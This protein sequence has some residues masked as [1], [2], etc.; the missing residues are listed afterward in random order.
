MMHRPWL[1]KSRSSRHLLL[2]DVFPT[3]PLTL[4]F[5]KIWE[6]YLFTSFTY[7]PHFLVAAKNRTKAE[8]IYGTLIARDDSARKLPSE[9]FGRKT[10]EQIAT[11][12]GIS[13][14]SLQLALEMKGVQAQPE[15]TMRVVA[16]KN[17][18][19][20]DTL[21]GMLESMIDTR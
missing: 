19:G 4:S 21:R 13:V 8:T 7:V 20:I 16:D 10:L 12:S 11:E 2:L 18:I 5:S 14:R 3:P 1:I 9:G 15:M 17:G 6:K